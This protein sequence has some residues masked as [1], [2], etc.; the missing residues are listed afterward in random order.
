MELEEW[1]WLFVTFG[2]ISSFKNMEMSEKSETF[3][4]SSSNFFPTR[5]WG[6]PY[7]HSPLALFFT[8]EVFSTPLAKSQFDILLDL[9]FLHSALF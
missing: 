6:H 5:I 2:D 4:P 9:D 7:F 3:F 1:K 8:L